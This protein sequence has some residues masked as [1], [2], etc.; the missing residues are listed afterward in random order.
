[1]D[2]NLTLKHR[3]DTAFFQII[4]L[5]PAHRKDLQTM[6]RVA[7]GRWNELDIELI[8][9]RKQNKH[10]PKYQEL[11]MDL[12]KRLDLIEQYLT[13]ATLLTK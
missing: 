13:F 8:T 11:E 10:T 1:M 4:D 9:C 3:I 12:V 2:A 5:A 7:R 6:W